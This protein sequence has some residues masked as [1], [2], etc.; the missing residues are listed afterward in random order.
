MKNNPLPFSYTSL[1]I[2]GGAMKS[3]SSIGS[4]TYLDD[5]GLLAPI[6]NV[7]GTS[8][9]TVIGLFVVLGYQPKDMVRFLMQYLSFDEVSNLNVDD[10]FSIFDTYG[11]SRGK[12]LEHFIAMMLYEKLKVK[13]TSFM[14]LA[15]HT[16]KNFVVCVSNISK[17]RFEYWSLDTTPQ[18]SVVKAIRTS[19]AIPI[20]FTPTT[21]NDDVYVDGALLNNFPIDYFQGS[22]LKD[23]LGI[24]VSSKHL[25]SQGIANITDY[26]N[27]IMQIVFRRLTEPHHTDTRNNVITL[28]LDDMSWVSL[29]EMRVNVSKEMME[30]YI[31]VGYTKMKELLQTHQLKMEE[32]TLSS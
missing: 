3:V 10:I 4:L 9:G 19:C 8:A 17:S 14:E 24:N 15:K 16:G 11:I 18:M 22:A 31:M 29:S 20:L 23:V 12:N 13:D 28:E 25:S 27:A 6:K 26:M 32:L 7:V 1:V 21:Y 2:S 30:N 5:V